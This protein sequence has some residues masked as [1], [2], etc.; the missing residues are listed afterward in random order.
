MNSKFLRMKAFLSKY[1]PREKRE[2]R[3]E[4]FINIRKSTMSVEESTIGEYS[5]VKMPKPKAFEGARSVKEL[6]NF[7]WDMEQYFKTARV[8]ETDMWNITIMYLMGD[9]KLWWR[10][11]NNLPGVI[12]IADSLVVFRSNR[13]IANVYSTSKPKGVCKMENLMDNTNDN[14]KAVMKEGNKDMTRN[15]DCNLKDCT[16]L[17]QGLSNLGKGECFAC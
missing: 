11:E 16:T 6:E 12:V 9:A 13:L 10:T 14:G 17:L 8:A 5:K 7:I 4:E 3:V 1:F 2:V 15:K